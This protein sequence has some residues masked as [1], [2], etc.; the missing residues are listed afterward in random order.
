MKVQEQFD[1]LSL[2]YR[3]GDGTAWNPTAGIVIFRSLASAAA[4][5][6]AAATPAWWTVMYHVG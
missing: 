1:L 4:F 6:S 5:R 3:L 2:F